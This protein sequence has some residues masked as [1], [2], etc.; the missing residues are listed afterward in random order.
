MTDVEN[1]YAEAYK[2]VKERYNGN[3]PIKAWDELGKL[4]TELGLSIGQGDRITKIVDS[5]GLISI[6]PMRE[7]GD[8][9]LSNIKDDNNPY[10]DLMQEIDKYSEYADQIFEE[11][12]ILMKKTDDLVN[13]V[14]E[15]VKIVADMAYKNYKKGNTRE[16]KVYGG[17]AT[18]VGIAT[19]LYGKYK[20]AELTER[21]ERQMEELLRMKQEIAEKK[22]AHVQK[23][24]QTFRQGVLQ[25][26]MTLFISE[27]DKVVNTDSN[28]NSELKMFKRKYLMMIKSL[29]LVK[30]LEYVEN[31]MQAWLMGEHSSEELRPLVA[32]VVDDTIYALYDEGKLSREEISLIIRGCKEAKLASVFILSE[33][34]LL[35]RHVGLKLTN[36]AGYDHDSIFASEH[37]G[38]PLVLSVYGTISK[39]YD[40]R[41][42]YHIADTALTECIT[43]SQYYQKCKDTI[44]SSFMDVPTK[45]VIPLKRRMLSWILI[46]LISLVICIFNPFTGICAAILSVVAYKRDCKK[47]EEELYPVQLRDYMNSAAK[48]VFNIIDEF[49]TNKL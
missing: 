22:L 8:I 16:A 20:E 38:S 17:A 32:E 21:Q 31:E 37:Y 27:L 5:F 25:K 47:K 12:T 36:S 44:E 26:T 28:I 49:K 33:P 4:R 19:W 9:T 14:G 39:H 35:R 10:S 45:G 40:D 11:T 48:N 41:R 18:I 30:V 15:Y 46:P 42:D 1:K 24:C 13:Q 23:Q 7:R 6:H 34:Y 43:K 29:Y 3:L 2:Q